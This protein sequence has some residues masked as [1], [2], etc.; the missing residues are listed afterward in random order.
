MLALP[1]PTRGSTRERHRERDAYPASPAH[2]GIDPG[3]N[4]S[5]SPRKCFPR[6]R[7]DR[8]SRH[9]SKLMKCWLPPP[10]RGS[11]SGIQ[12][13][14]PPHHASPAHAGIDPV[15]QNRC[16]QL[17]GFPRPRGDRPCFMYAFHA[18]ESLPPP[19][20]GS[21]L[22]RPS[23][24]LR[25][26]ASPAHAGIDLWYSAI[27]NAG[28]SFPRPR[29]DRPDLTQDRTAAQMLPPPTRGST[30]GCG[31]AH[32]Q[33]GASPAHAGIDPETGRYRRDFTGFPRP[34]GDRPIAAATDAARMMLPPPTRGSTFVK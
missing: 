20:R 32:L 9:I 33:P 16:R 2:A 4:I 25:L 19:T 26:L 30:R 15:R 27:T 10:T 23:W 12:S 3:R 34:R 29:G 11:T 13:Q 14:P 28:P 31:G 18:F 1:P 6:P 21:T 8:P 22:K 24:V 7:G 17:P 5:R